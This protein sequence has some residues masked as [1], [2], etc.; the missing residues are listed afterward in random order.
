MLVSYQISLNYASYAQNMIQVIS[1]VGL[2]LGQIDEHCFSN[3]AGGQKL[4][5]LTSHLN[6]VCGNVRDQH[7]HTKSVFWFLSSILAQ[8]RTC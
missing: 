8:Q 5:H 6:S 4:N 1:Y 2:G 7:D 3:N